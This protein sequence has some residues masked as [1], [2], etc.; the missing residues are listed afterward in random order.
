MAR[1]SG[2]SHAYGLAGLTDGDVIRQGSVDLGQGPYL[3]RVYARFMIPLGKERDTA[4]RGQDQV[5]GS[6]T[7]SP[8][9]NQS[10][11]VRAER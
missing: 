5:P 7:V 8:Y 2:V 1:G 10:R 3:A 6:G 4:D 9:R 11:Q